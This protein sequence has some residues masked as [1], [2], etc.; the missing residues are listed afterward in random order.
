MDAVK[1]LLAEAAVD[2]MAAGKFSPA[3]AAA[4]AV[5]R[6]LKFAREKLKLDPEEVLR[7]AERAVR[8]GRTG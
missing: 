2:L 6:I 3:D 8:A 5:A 4:E 1:L 7:R